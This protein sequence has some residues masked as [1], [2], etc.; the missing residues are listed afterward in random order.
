M[1]PATVTRLPLPEFARR[2]DVQADDKIVRLADDVETMRRDVGAL[3]VLARQNA[4]AQRATGDA[5]SAMSDGIGVLATRIE[6]LEGGVLEAVA[7][8]GRVERALD[9]RARD[10]HASDVDLIARVEREQAARE[11]EDARLLALVQRSV[12]PM[13]EGVATSA[14]AEASGTRKVVAIA[15]GGLATVYAVVQILREIGV[16][17]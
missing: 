11:A 5:M 2:T 12:A 1:S 15:S 4:Q 9:A 6:A 13:V 17:R 7:G 8:I 3:D 10:A 14:A 16:I